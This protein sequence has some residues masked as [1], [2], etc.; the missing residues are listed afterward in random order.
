[1]AEIDE[2]GELGPLLTTKSLRGPQSAFDIFERLAKIVALV[3]IPIVIPMALAMY[4]KKEESTAQTQTLNRDYVQLA[5]SILKEK[6]STTNPQIRRWAF[7]LLSAHSPT[8][9]DPDVLAGLKSGELSLFG[10]V[11]SMN[12]VGAV[13]DDGKISAFAWANKVELKWHTGM[14]QDITTSYA[15]IMALD[16]SPDGKYLA[17]GE[18]GG[19]VQIVNIHNETDE[20]DEFETDQPLMDLRYARDGKTIRIY[21]YRGEILIYKLNGDLVKKIASPFPELVIPDN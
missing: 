15:H 20:G 21:T 4:S 11:E 18:S 5:V 10:D 7:D 3:A 16:F 19:N 1:M 9:F 8:K 13:T 14:S 2:G 17:I 6:K 12:R